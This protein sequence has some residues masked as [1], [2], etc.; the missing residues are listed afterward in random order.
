MTPE[1]IEKANKHLLP[2]G[3]QL[4]NCKFVKRGLKLGDLK[5]NLFNITLRYTLKSLLIYKYRFNKLL[6]FK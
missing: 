5:G 6:K 2:L 1:K 4:G 3:I